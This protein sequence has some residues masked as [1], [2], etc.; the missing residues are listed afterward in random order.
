[1][2]GVPI[3]ANVPYTYE[4]YCYLP[5]DGKR[6]EIID[7]ELY[8]SPAPSPFH[9][10]VSR[11]L[12]QALMRQLEDTGIALIFNAPIDVI[13][14]ETTVVQ[15]DLAVL[16]CTRKEL[17]TNR[18][19]EGPPDLVVEILSPSNKGNDLFLKRSAYA[20]HGFGEYW[21][22]DPDL[23]AINVLRLTPSGYELFARF[24]RAG[25]VSSPSFA[26]IS[27][28]LAPVFRAI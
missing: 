14:G 22:V 24:D 18:G 20:H 15:P 19:I 3:H 26:E 17:I 1:M 13:I 7:G 5:A 25:T 9:Q 16:R 10:T 11:R 21:I 8:V 4:A 27:V 6:Y 12:Q 23:G 2:S 28:P